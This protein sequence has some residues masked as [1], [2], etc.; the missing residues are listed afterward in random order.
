MNTTPLTTF[1]QRGTL[2]HMKPDYTYKIVTGWF[3]LQGHTVVMRKNKGRN[4]VAY[5]DIENVYEFV[6][7]A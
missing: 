6:P 3:Y 2:T 7:N 1:A 5:C 4:E